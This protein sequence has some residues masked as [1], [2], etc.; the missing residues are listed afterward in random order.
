MEE[1]PRLQPIELAGTEGASGIQQPVG[2]IDGPGGKGQK[3]RQTDGERH[4]VRPGKPQRP[5]NGDR[6]GIQAKKVPQPGH[7]EQVKLA[8]GCKGLR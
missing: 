4:S 5:G 3:E 7:G 2:D 8:G 6:R 1:V